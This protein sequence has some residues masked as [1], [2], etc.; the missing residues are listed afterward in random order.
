MLA[1]CHCCLYLRIHTIIRSILIR[2][3][4]VTVVYVHPNCCSVDFQFKK[5]V[6]IHLYRNIDASFCSSSA[7][8]EH[9]LHCLH[10]SFVLKSVVTV[11][12]RAEHNK[13]NHHVHTVDL[14]TPIFMFCSW[15]AFYLLVFFAFVQSVCLFGYIGNVRSIVNFLA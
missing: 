9:C 5:I 13:F 11:S 12:D 8:H 1:T 3:D 7:A 14:L 10:W 6:L 15:F 4:L 2:L